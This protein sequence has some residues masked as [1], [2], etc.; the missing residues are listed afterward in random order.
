MYGTKYEGV[1]GS[2]GGVMFFV[3][4]MAKQ[5]LDLTSL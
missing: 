5:E 4:G 1:V 2:S 3:F